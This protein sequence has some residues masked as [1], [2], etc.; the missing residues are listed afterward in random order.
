MKGLR[1]WLGIRPVPEG[2]LAGAWILAAGLARTWDSAES[3]LA[4]FPGDSQAC[5]VRQT[6]RSAST[7]HIDSTTLTDAILAALSTSLFR[8]QAFVSK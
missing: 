1:A 4:S 8:C 2:H 3:D 7:D 5:K 6:A